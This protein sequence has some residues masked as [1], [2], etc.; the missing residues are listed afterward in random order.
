MIPNHILKNV[1]ATVVAMNAVAISAKYAVLKQIA[2]LCILLGH[3]QK[4]KLPTTNPQKTAEII[5]KQ[6]HT[7]VADKINNIMDTVKTIDR[8]KLTLR[9]ESF[10]EQSIFHTLVIMENHCVCE[11]QIKFLEKYGDNPRVLGLLKRIITDLLTNKFAVPI[12]KPEDR[13]EMQQDAYF[14]EPG[15][16]SMINEQK[17][18]LKKFNKLLKNPPEMTLEQIKAECKAIK[19]TITTA[20]YKWLKTAISLYETQ[21]EISALKN[22]SYDNSNVWESLESDWNGRFNE[23]DFFIL[24]IDSGDSLCGQMMEETLNTYDTG[25]PAKPF[26]IR[27]EQDIRYVGLYGRMILL[28]Y[29]LFYFHRVWNR[30]KKKTPLTT[31]NGPGR[32]N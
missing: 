7:T 3:D 31:E 12:T 13:L 22:P 8:E 11:I 15:Y 9:I 25:S 16:K 20:Q 10:C 1:A 29:N 6:L 14:D 27:S 4:K 18:D 17:R 24:M 28:Y 30:P 2:S 32:V 23:P 26:A 5:E 21:N 19:P